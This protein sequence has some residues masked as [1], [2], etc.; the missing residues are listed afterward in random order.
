M[1]TRRWQD[2]NADII[3]EHMS[4]ALC[5]LGNLSYR[6][7]R[8]LTFNPFAGKF[9]NDDDANLYLTREYCYP[10]IVPDKV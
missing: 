6:T 9:V 7:G 5:H 2:L 8:K 10:Y 1:R 4:S 3:E